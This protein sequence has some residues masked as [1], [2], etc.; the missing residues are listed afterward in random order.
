MSKSVGLENADGRPMN[1][2]ER[3]KRALA[4]YNINDEKINSRVR[5]A[6]GGASIEL[7]SA[8][9]DIEVKKKKKKKARLKGNLDL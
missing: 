2:P 4:K 1:T 8:Y 5:S 9:V 3:V 6:G 7:F